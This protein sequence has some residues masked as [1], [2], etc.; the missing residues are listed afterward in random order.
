[1]P[2][3]T[4]WYI[5]ACVVSA[6]DLRSLFAIL[7]EHSPCWT[8]G[9]NPT[10]QS[11]LLFIMDRS[12]FPGTSTESHQFNVAKSGPVSLPLPWH[13]KQVWV[14]S[15]QHNPYF[16]ISGFIWSF[17]DLIMRRNIYVCENRHGCSW[18][19]FSS[20][21]CWW[22]CFFLVC[23]QVPGGDR[24][25]WTWC[26]VLAIAQALITA[27]RHSE[28][29]WDACGWIGCHYSSKWCICPA[30]LALPAPSQGWGRGEGNTF[31]P[32][33]TC[34]PPTCLALWGRKTWNHHTDLSVSLPLSM[35][36]EMPQVPSLCSCFVRERH[37]S[38]PLILLNESS[39]ISRLVRKRNVVSLTL[40]PG[41]ASQSK[42]RSLSLS[43]SYH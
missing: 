20:L 27:F 41:A 21:F 39:C 23:S 2:L 38:L 35:G 22:H 3:S 19:Y 40:Q 17:E 6:C 10:A 7:W 37:C 28:I 8:L 14:F 26:S 16:C 25:D 12:V 34:W 18:K 29:I 11:M 43:F 24:A 36:E 33:R 1:M 4:S 9:L 42:T 5:K 32:P 15:L 31:S 30:G 13:W